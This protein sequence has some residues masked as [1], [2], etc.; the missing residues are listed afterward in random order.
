MVNGDNLNYFF[1]LMDQKL[2]QAGVP[3]LGARLHMQ[4]N[5]EARINYY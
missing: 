1:F 5:A 2:G 3:K 4:K